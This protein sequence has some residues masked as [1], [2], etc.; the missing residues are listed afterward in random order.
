MKKIDKKIIFKY[1]FSFKI[2]YE[3]L[4]LFPKLISYFKPLVKLPYVNDKK[5]L[6]S[7]KLGRLHPN[8]TLKG[9]FISL[10][11]LLI[12]IEEVLNLKIFKDFNFLKI[13]KNKKMLSQFHHFFNKLK[14]NQSKYPHT[15]Y[16]IF[17]IYF[18]NFKLLGLDKKIKN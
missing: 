12:D 16:S 9:N 3:I 10:L 18:G 2:F 7:K 8:Q 11:I 4:I 6:H 14:V 17:K 13:S 5:L 1:N 15:A